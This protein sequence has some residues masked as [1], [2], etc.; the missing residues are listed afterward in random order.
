MGWLELQGRMVADT[1]TGA[2]C[3]H[4]CTLLHTPKLKAAHQH[5]SRIGSCGTQMF[6]WTKA[7]HS[8][9]HTMP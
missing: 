8:L 3:P 5:K 1:G 4:T 2:P 9:P 7:V 6:D